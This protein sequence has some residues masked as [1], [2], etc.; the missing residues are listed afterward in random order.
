MFLRVGLC[1][2]VILALGF[3]AGLAPGDSAEATVAHCFVSYPSEWVINTRCTGAWRRLGHTFTGDLR[4]AHVGTDWQA[5]PPAPGAGGWTEVTVPAG[6]HTRP[7]VAVAG[8]AS[9][10]PGWVWS[11]R[12]LLILAAAGWLALIARLVLTRRR[13]A[14]ARSG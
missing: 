4:G 11:I 12:V 9:A 8:L 2:L 7:V 1:T 10:A 13:A 14:A 5:I 3:V 6:E